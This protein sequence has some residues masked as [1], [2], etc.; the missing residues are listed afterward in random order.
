MTFRVD[1]V[2]EKAGEVLYLS[3]RIE[4]DDLD[5]LRGALGGDS[6]SL[7]LDL[8]GLDLVDGEAVTF[9]GAIEASGGTLRHCPPF[10]R[11]WIDRDRAKAESTESERG[12]N[13]E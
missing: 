13:M 6:A 4:A 11:E 1:R 5:A 9:L 2:V 10:I 7:T 3:G 8:R 12:C